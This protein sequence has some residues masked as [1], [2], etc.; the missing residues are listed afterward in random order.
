MVA[1]SV[2]PGGNPLESRDTKNSLL[3]R[4]LGKESA[5]TIETAD[6]IHFTSVHS[7]LPLTAAGQQQLEDGAPKTDLTNCIERCRSATWHGAP[8]RADLT[9]RCSAC[10]KR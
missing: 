6:A 5:K 8:R 3:V 4:E 1:L 2:C 10:S 7:F 9:V